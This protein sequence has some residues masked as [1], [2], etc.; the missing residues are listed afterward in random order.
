MAGVVGLELEKGRMG[1]CQVRQTSHGLKLLRGASLPLPPGLLT[2]SLAEPNVTAEEEFTAQLRH[3]LKKTGWRGGRVVLALPD[4]TCRVGRQ[5]FEEL[6]GTSAD[7]RELLR[8]RLKDRLPF[9][10]HEARI[11]YQPL[12]SQGNGTRLLYLLAREA[13]IAQYEAL[14]LRVGLEPIRIITRGVALARFLTAAGLRGKRFFLA[15]GPS[16]FSLIY[17]EEGVPLLWRVLPVDENG[18]PE[19]LNHRAERVLRELHETVAYLGEEM[20]VKA[21]DEL[22]VM[23]GTDLLLIER[24]MEAR[25]LPVRTL[26]LPK[27]A[28][29]ADLLVP[30]GAALMRYG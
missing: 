1:L 12:P 23:K 7:I 27:G 3:L 2:P 14:L 17:A 30:A 16:S 19:E 11:D 24:L 9:P 18:T 6:K 22:L 15:L 25:Q 13:V 8:W 29:A 21:I 5:D 28:P 10:A 4:L 26:P 20:G